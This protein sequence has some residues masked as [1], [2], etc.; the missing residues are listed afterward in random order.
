MQTTEAMIP[1][2]ESVAKGGRCSPRCRHRGIPEMNNRKVMIGAVSAMLLSVGLTGQAAHAQ[3]VPGFGTTRWTTLGNAEVVVN[4]TVDNAQTSGFLT[5]YPCADGAPNP[6]TSNVNF[7][8][9]Q[10]TST[11]AVVRSDAH[12]DVCVLSNTVADVIVDQF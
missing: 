12:G 11:A 7:R 10:T 8:A 5:A 9:G 6:L 4:L 3:Q 2:V 1:A